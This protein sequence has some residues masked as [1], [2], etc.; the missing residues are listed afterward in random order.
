MHVSKVFYRT[1]EYTA[2]IG[3]NATSISEVRMTPLW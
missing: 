1:F 3:T 2:F